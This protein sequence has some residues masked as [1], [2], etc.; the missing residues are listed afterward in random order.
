LLIVGEESS[1]VDFSN[2]TIPPG[3]NAEKMRAGLRAATDKLRAN[4]S[5]VDMVLTTSEEAAFAE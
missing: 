4:G 1:T 3:M 5:G 2:P